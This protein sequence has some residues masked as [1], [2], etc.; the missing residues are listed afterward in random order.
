[1][2]LISFEIEER[3]K[4]LGY[5]QLIGGLI[6]LYVIIKWFANEPVL[7]GLK[8]LIYLLITSFFV[9]SIYCG[10]QLRK[11][12]IKAIELSKWNQILQVIQF[13]IS[14]VAFAYYSG[15]NFSLGLVLTDKMTPD[16]LISLSGF[17]FHYTP[18]ESNF[19]VMINI[20]PLVVI[21]LLDGL[22]AKIDLR[23]ELL[24]IDED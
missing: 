15:I 18:N 21:Y 14:A 16:F 9:L 1:M 5:Y 4:L 8:L 10:N 2:R 13:N 17:A 12:D 23:S 19:S 11:G 7:S 22:Q 24:K 20:V 3:M 6:G